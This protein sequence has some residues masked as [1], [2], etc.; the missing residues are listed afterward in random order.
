MSKSSQ[1]ELSAM[2]ELYQYAISYAKKAIE[3]EKK[4]QKKAALDNYIKAVE[5]LNKMIRWAPTPEQKEAYYR[6][7]KTYL[8]R[9][10]EIRKELKKPGGEIGE[11]KGELSATIQDAIITERPMIKWDDVADLETAKQALREAIILPLLRPD[12]FKGA[13]KPWRG[14]LLFGP[15]G[16]G[17]TLLAKAVASECDATFFNVSAATLV[18]KWLGESEKLVRELF[19]FSRKKQPSIVFFDEVDAIATTRGGTEHDAIRR[20]KLQLMQEMQGL[21]TEVSEQIVVIGTTNVPWTIDPAFRRRFEKRILVPLPGKEAREQI[22][23]IHT[24]DVELDESV[25][26]NLLAEITEG[27]SGADIEIVCR[28]AI[29]NPVR[30]MD[31]SGLLKDKEAKI[32]PVTIED[33]EKALQKIKPTVAPEEL[34]GYEEWQQEFGSL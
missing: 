18:S 33:F 32:R 14:V 27:F 21:A 7:A 30:E 17:K 9:A 12:L 23:R 3:N 5:I 20:V 11:E 16:C 6:K 28:E 19:K 25:V 8:A 26:F 15:P 2:Q 13:R 34:L 1:K 4:G 24:K 31:K 29:M 10:W 22:F